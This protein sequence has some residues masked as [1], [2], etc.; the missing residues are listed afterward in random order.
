MSSR[1]VRKQRVVEVKRLRTLN[2]YHPAGHT[3]SNPN[4]KDEFKRRTWVP[5]YYVVFDRAGEPW[6]LDCAINEDYKKTDAERLS[7]PPRQAE[8]YIPGVVAIRPPARYR[9]PPS[10]EEMM[11]RFPKFAEMRQFYQTLTIMAGKVGMPED[12]LDKHI[13]D[14]LAAAGKRQIDHLSELTRKKLLRVISGWTPE[15]ARI[16]ED[17]KNHK[18]NS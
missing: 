17:Q 16:V 1:A 12:V 4:C 15:N 11:N 3:C 6:C 18:R 9:R 8:E 14:T 5:L 13:K 7:S 10:T 2:D